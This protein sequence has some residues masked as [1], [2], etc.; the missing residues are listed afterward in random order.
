MCGVVPLNK[1]EGRGL[2]LLLF[3]F[4]TIKKERAVIVI[5]SIFRFS[6]SIG[7]T[8]YGGRSQFKSAP[9]QIAPIVRIIIGVEM[10]VSESFIKIRGLLIFIGQIADSII[11]IE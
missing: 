5:V 2:A 10:F 3:I 6:G 8:R 7:T 1:E 4:Q 9:P 11:R